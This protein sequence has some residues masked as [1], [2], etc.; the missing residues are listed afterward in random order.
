MTPTTEIGFNAEQVLI[1]IL[2]TIPQLFA[3]TPVHED[4]D[5]D[6]TKNRIVVQCEERLEESPN[7]LVPT[8]TVYRLKMKVMVRA[9]L[10]QSSAGDLYSAFGTI[11]DTLENIN[12]PSFSTLP[13]IAKFT[14]LVFAPGQESTREKEENRRKMTKA[15]DLVGYLA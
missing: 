14:M 5:M 3:L 15:L 2:S 4:A 10:G 8:Q 13:S 9:A 12:G 6:N 7:Y 11:C 1:E